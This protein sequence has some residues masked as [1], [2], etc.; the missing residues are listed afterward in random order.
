L[1][2]NVCA[3]VRIHPHYLSY[4]NELAGGPE[5]GWRHLLESNIDWGQDL[6][7]LKRWVEEHSEARPLKLAY[8]GDVD[9]H[10][11]GL[12]YQLPPAGDSLSS[13]GPQPSWY[14]ISANLVYEAEWVGCDEHGRSIYFAAG[15]CSH[16]GRITPVDKAGYSIFLYHVVDEEVNRARFRHEQP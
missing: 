10:L 16:F 6:L 2:W 8:Y 13:K 14:A 7:F 1:A 9:P 4:F 12:D 11:L 3:A 5:N 15:D